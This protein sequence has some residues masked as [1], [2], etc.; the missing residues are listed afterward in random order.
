MRLSPGVIAGAGIS[1]GLLLLAPR[2]A[3]AK[4]SAPLVVKQ[5]ETIKLAAQAEDFAEARGDAPPAFTF[6]SRKYPLYQDK[7]E[8]GVAIWQGLLAIPADLKPGSYNLK[9]GEEDLKLRVNAGQFPVQRISLPKS[10]DN[11]DMSAGEK[12][13]IEGAKAT[14]SQ[15]KFWRGKF[16]QPCNARQSARFGLRRVVNGRLLKDYY[17]TGLDFAAPLGKA[18]CATAPGR[19]I[20]ARTGF[21]L[22]GN[23]VAIDHGQGVIS[24]YIHLQRIA[25]KEGQM[26]EAGEKI[27]AVGQSGRATGPHLHFGIY[28]NETASNPVQWFSAAF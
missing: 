15:E 12:E 9:I 13:A 28:V 8:A 23:T 14:I 21:K 1:L 6:N 22:H 25:V 5:G 18:V 20:L 16:A 10:K 24:F 26:V 4:I 17:H 11:F 19:V 27:G 3:L 7:S 2:F